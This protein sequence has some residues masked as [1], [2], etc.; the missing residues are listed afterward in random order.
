VA[1]AYEAARLAIRSDDTEEARRQFQRAVE[2]MPEFTEGW[3]NL[4][5]STTILAIR[6][7]GAGDD[8]EALTLFRE[9]VAAKRR[10]QDLIGEGKWFIY[11]DPERA[12]V[13][14]D[15]TEALPE[16][17]EVL[18]DESSLLIALRLYA[19]RQGSGDP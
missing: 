18:A 3:Y 19:E 17:D 11:E 13:V 14:H 2:L 9:A 7:A 8:A 15:L 4:G 6:A 12:K 5:A 10:A 16:A 1:T